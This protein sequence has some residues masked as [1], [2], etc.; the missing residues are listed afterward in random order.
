MNREQFIYSLQMNGML[1]CL[2]GF[3]RELK[4]VQLAKKILKLDISNIF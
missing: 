2:D 4:K 3:Y 1:Q